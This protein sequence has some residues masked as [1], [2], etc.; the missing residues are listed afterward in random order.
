MRR[1]PI[2]VKSNK[3]FRQPS[4]RNQRWERWVFA[5]FVFSHVFLLCFF[6]LLEF[7][8]LYQNK[9]NNPVRRILG[10][11]IR[12]CFFFV[13]L[14][15]FAVPSPTVQKLEENQKRQEIQSCEKNLG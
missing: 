14:E 4:C 11:S 9:K 2:H 7:P 13:F 3:D 5:R 8:D 12:D 15:V 10:K 6:P 1:G